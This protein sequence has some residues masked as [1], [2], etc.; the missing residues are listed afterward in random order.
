LY[1]IAI[2]Q[3][4]FPQ[5]AAPMCAAADQRLDESRAAALE[6]GGSEAGL[7]VLRKWIE[8]SISGWRRLM[9]RNI[10]R[11]EQTPAEASN[12]P[13]L[14]IDQC[15]AILAVA[16]FISP[17]CS[18][19]SAAERASPERRRASMPK[20]RSLEAAGSEA[21][22]VDSPQAS[23]IRMWIE[24][25]AA[26]MAERVRGL[27]S[28]PK[29]HVASLVLAALVLSTVVGSNSAAERG[30]A[31]ARRA[32]TPDVFK[33]CSE[34]IPDADRITVCLRQKVRE[35]SPE[36]RVVMTGVKK[37]EATVGAPRNAGHRE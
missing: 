18:A 28:R 36:C 17:L 32:C 1:F 15:T 2:H 16:F 5:A 8:F 19:A 30:T 29:P 33:H 27:I 37:A 6:R 4:S 35:L 9:A 3:H 10:S 34:F 20:K 7:L 12:D 22:R 11:R 14:I 26:R 23:K 31:E 21:P 13:V 24:K 25:T